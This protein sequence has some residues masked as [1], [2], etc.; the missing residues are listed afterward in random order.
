MTVDTLWYTRC[1]VPTASGYAL[2]A[3]LLA[4][5][6]GQVGVR[7]TDLATSDDPAIRRSHFDHTVANSI[8]QGGNIPP[9]VA[10]ARGADVRVIGFSWPTISHRVLVSPDSGIADVAGLAGR[11]LALP[12]RRDD[13]SDFWRPTVLRGYTQALATAGLGLDD[14]TLVD[15]EVAG[16]HRE[17]PSTPSRSGL[18][19]S[20]LSDGGFQRHEAAALLRGDVDAV[21]SEHSSN[22]L[23]RHVLGLRPIVELAPLNGEK[24]VN[25]GIPLVV[26]ASGELIDSRPDLVT[27]WLDRIVRTP[28]WVRDHPDEARRIYA[29]ESGLPE[30][31]I[32][33]AFPGPL[34]QHV[35]LD[36]DDRSIEAYASQNAF[37]FEHGFIDQPV[38]LD[39]F[40]QTDLLEKVLADHGPQL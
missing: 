1:P 3:G 21:F 6:F 32:D 2:A 16:R 8:R 25:N 37:L 30:D 9:L 29:L 39:T 11:R 31:L 12:V 35:V 28:R 19:R 27:T 40:V 13:P 26:S 10:R 18:A 38:D 34:E 33:E 36:V 4:D 5:D 14:V 20:P 7:L 23:L 24:A 22:A 15:V 17:Q